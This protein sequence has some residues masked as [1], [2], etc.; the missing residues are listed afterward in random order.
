MEAEPRMTKG[1]RCSTAASSGSLEH[2]AMNSLPVCDGTIP[3][4]VIAVIWAFLAFFAL[5]LKRRRI[6]ALL[7]P[8]YPHFTLFILHKLLKAVMQRQAAVTCFAD[9]SGGNDDRKSKR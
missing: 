9:R 3:T 5:F 2:S 8:P 1:A 4:S 7:I 6:P